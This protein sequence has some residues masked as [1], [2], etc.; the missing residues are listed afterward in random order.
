MQT[1]TLGRT[2]LTVSVA[3]LGCGGKSRL[4]QSQG[5]SFEHS[6]DLVKLALDEGVTLI[7]TAAAYGT[8]EI[9]G[10]AIEGR[11]D[12]VVIST[13]IP[14][15]A[16]GAPT[17][18]MIGPDALEE[19]VDGCLQRL[20]TDRIDVLHLHGV[21]A[22]QYDHAGTALLERMARMRDKGKIRF[23]GLTERF[24]SDTTHRMAS[25]A[26]EDG[27]FDVIMLG[28]N[29]VNQTALKDVLPAAERNGMGTLAMFAV[30][31]PLARRETADALVRKLVE[32]G[33]VDPATFDATDPLGLLTAPGVA[34]SLTEAAYRF[35]QHAPGIQ[36]TVT[37]TGD[38][39]PL[40]ANL[41]AINMGP[42][43][44]DVLVRL[45]R[46]FGKVTSESADP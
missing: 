5:R 46:M 14:I 9:V 2:G 21:A 22:D 27:A 41:A 4:G 37:G 12:A 13:K 32:R 43:P 16:H 15:S 17:S 44:G 38:P 25:R 1:T 28:L 29:Y 19:A 39:D 36:V 33:E 26:V 42:L 20:R 6:V 18:E 30:R 7:D 35:C 34:A 3:G 31:G 8:E 45:S 10:A 23:T 11:R 24:A 40:R